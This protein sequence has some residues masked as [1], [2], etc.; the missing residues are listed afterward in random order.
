M[1]LISG[2]RSATTPPRS[3]AVPLS[4]PAESSRS[5]IGPAQNAAPAKRAGPAD[6]NL[7]QL[8]RP[9][10]TGR[11]APHP[12]SSASPLISI[13]M[14]AVARCRAWFPNLDG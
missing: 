14:I 13:T 9:A 6:E 11:P 5:Q 10:S 12:R 7:P 4:G 1:L 2:R 3:A 8:T